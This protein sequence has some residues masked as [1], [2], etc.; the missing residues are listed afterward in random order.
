MA[1]VAVMTALLDEGGSSFGC[2]LTSWRDW[3]TYNRFGSQAPGLRETIAGNWRIRFALLS[4]C[5]LLL[6]A[7]GVKHSTEP[8]PLTP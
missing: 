1:V 4:G 6:V 8:L 5:L 2:L 3:L 7:C